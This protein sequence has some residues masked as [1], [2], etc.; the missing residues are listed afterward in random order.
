V[1]PEVETTELISNQTIDQIIQMLSEDLSSM[2][3]G[4][5]RSQ[6]TLNHHLKIQNNKYQLMIDQMRKTT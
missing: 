5:S 2:K 6:K 4:E 3:D 1:E